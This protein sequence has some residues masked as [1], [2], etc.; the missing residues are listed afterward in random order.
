M[1]CGIYHGDVAINTRV[2]LMG[3]NLSVVVGWVVWPTLGRKEGCTGVVPGGITQGTDYGL[4]QSL[5]IET[6]P[7]LRCN[8]DMCIALTCA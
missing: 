7:L 2:L 1:N 5:A 4:T 6:E 8:R 3:R